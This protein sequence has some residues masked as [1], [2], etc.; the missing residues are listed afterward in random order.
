[1]TV[2]R[3]SLP[4]VSS[5][6][7][8]IG[9]LPGSAARAVRSTNPGTSGAAATREE[10]FRNSRRFNIARLRGVHH[11]GHKGHKEDTNTSFQNCLSFVL[12]VSFVV[13][14]S[15]IQLV[16]WQRQQH[17]PGVPAALG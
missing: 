11:K 6:T 14:L 3:P 10:R 17:E 15:S 1:M 5:R 7:M 8:R 16:L 4:P 13:K 2:L 12:F 9:S